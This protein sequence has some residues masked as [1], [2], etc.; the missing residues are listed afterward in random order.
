MIRLFANKIRVVATVSDYVQQLHQP[1]TDIRNLHHFFGRAPE[2][3][4][5]RYQRDKSLSN[6]W[7]A[8]R[9]RQER[10]RGAFMEQMP[11]ELHALIPNDYR[12]WKGHGAQ[13][14]S[15]LSTTWSY[16]PEV[17]ENLFRRLQHRN[18]TGAELASLSLMLRGW[19][20]KS[21]EPGGQYLQMIANE[22][23]GRDSHENIND[24]TNQPYYSDEEKAKK[25]GENH[26]LREKLRS[27]PMH[28]RLKELMGE[29]QTQSQDEF[30]KQHGDEGAVL[31]RGIGRQYAQRIADRIKQ[32]KSVPT[33]SINSYTPSIESAHKFSNMG[34]SNTNLDRGIWDEGTQTATYPAWDELAQNGHVPS[35]KSVYDKGYS[36]LSSYL[37]YK[38]PEKDSMDS[39]VRGQSF[40]S[41]HI[42]PQD[43]FLH[44]NVVGTPNPNI[45]DKMDTEEE[46][47]IPHSDTVPHMVHTYNMWDLSDAAKKKTN[48]RSFVAPMSVTASPNFPEPAKQ[49]T[50][51]TFQPSLE[52][53]SHYGN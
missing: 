29:L 13:E 5:Q 51:D 36:S 3:R 45:H 14:A 18:P 38:E 19:N 6:A 25:R 48:N 49:Q 22:L 31:H 23:R 8:R 16:K 32:G 26:T 21:H 46:V 30:R 17:M 43:V 50:L 39:T 2:G 24:G 4:S 15:N 10:Q 40:L 27:N 9:Q 41:S 20:S 34:S 1:V 44:N 11:E 37:Q 42:K 33:N 52:K 7:R 12:P 28:E 35:A 47:Y 53:L